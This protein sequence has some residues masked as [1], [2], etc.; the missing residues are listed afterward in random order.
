MI[1]PTSE[2]P[3]ADQLPSSWFSD[4]P[5]LRRQSPGNVDQ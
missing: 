1:D 5:A 4:C 3:P 2:L